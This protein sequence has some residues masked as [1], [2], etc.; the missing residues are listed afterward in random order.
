LG[1]LLE[2]EKQ[3]EKERVLSNEVC[4]L[5][6][7]VCSTSFNPFP[8]VPRPRKLNFPT[9]SVSRLDPFTPTPPE[10]NNS[11]GDQSPTNNFKL[12]RIF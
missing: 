8:A 2:Y 6:A 12:V 5:S 9:K 11:N 4:T 3:L 10:E 1:Q 7:P